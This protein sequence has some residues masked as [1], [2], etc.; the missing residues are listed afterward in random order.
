MTLYVVPS[1][2]ASVA[3][4]LHDP[5]LLLPPPAAPCCLQTTPA[6]MMGGGGGTETPH[7]G[8]SIGDPVQTTHWLPRHWGYG[9]AG[10]KQAPRGSTEDTAAWYRAAPERLMVAPPHKQLPV[11]SFP[12]VIGMQSAALMHDRSYVEGST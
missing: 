10:Q 12:G 5:P 7:S 8:G 2:Q 1:L 6:S 11:H 3:W 9:A 4:T